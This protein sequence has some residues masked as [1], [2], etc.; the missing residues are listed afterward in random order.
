MAGVSALRVNSPVATPDS[1]SWQVWIIMGDLSASHFHFSWAIP[2]ETRERRV[3]NDDPAGDC[4]LIMR[5]AT[6]ARRFRMTEPSL[7]FIVPIQSRTASDQ[8]CGDAH[9]QKENSCRR[10]AAPL[11]LAAL[12][13]LWNRPSRKTR[14]KGMLIS[15]EGVQRHENT[16]SKGNSLRTPNKRQHLWEEGVYAWR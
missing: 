8:Q 1:R 7:R 10:L 11:Q 3:T 4:K 16:K 13:M 2:S 5:F 15:M 6:L 9:A 14:F 12:V